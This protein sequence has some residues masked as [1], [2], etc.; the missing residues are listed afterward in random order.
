[1]ARLFLLL[2]L[3]PG[4]S[5]GSIRDGDGGEPILD[6]TDG[7]AIDAGDPTVPGDDGGTVG[8]DGGTLGDDSGPGDQGGDPGGGS[9]GEILTFETGLTPTAEIHVAEGGNGDG[10][11]GN[12]Y[13]S[14][15]RAAQDAGPGSAIRVHSGTYPGGMH[16]SDL[17]GHAGAPIW[18]G[19]APGEPRPVI[20][21]GS[22]GIQLSRVRYLILHDLEFRNT[23]QNGVNCD[24]GT[25]YA[26]PDVTRYVIFRNL[27][28]H[29][30]G[31]GGNQDC[32]KLSGLDDYFVLDSEFARCGGGMSGSGIDHV[33]CHHGLIARCRFEHMSGNA[34]Q[35][36]GGSFDIEIRQNWMVDAGERSVNMGGSTGFTFFRPPLSTTQ[37]NTEARDIRVLANVMEGS[38]APIAFVGCV[39]CLAANNTIIDPDNWILRIL[40]ETTST[41]EYEFLPASNCTFANNLVYFS[42]GDLS[43][44]VNIGPD[45]AAETFTFTNNLWYAHDDPGQ[46]QPDN[47][48]SADIDPVVGEDPDFQNAA[49]HNYHIGSNSPAA[50]QGIPLTEVTGDMDGECYADPPAIGAYEAIN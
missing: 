50:G 30:I 9:C 13:G 39:D 33:G 14:I 36:K 28:I 16:I 21:G 38:S 8:D 24:D 40:Q 6:A 45:T 43:T 19:G 35:N 5:A 47:L 3:F 48:P 42:R 2:A 41:A 37:P 10:T 17:A 15:E 1:M 11:A 7:A 44:Y 20:E 27:Y 29:D 31:G 22:N 34:I 23:S 46:S 12:P 18:I 49:A 26:D 25:E 32:L 4:C